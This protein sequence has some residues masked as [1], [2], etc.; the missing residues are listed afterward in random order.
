MRLGTYML[1]VLA[2]FALLAPVAAS[3]DGLDDAG[4]TNKTSAGPR[5][6]D[7]QIGQAIEREFAFDSGVLAERIDVQTH[8]GIV[9]LSG[10]TDNLLSR[11]RAEYLAETVKGVRSVVNRIEVLPAVVKSDEDLARD[12]ED[13]LA[14]DPATRSYKAFVESHH[15]TV[16]LSGTVDSPLEKRLVDRVA[17]GVKGVR[18]VE[19]HVAVAY[20]APRSDAEIEKEVEAALHWDPLIDNGLVEVAVE[21]GEVHLVGTVGSAAERRRARED[22]W[23]SGVHHVQDDLEVAHWARDEE[24]R[25]EKYV[26]KSDEDIAAA[27]MAALRHDPRVFSFDVDTSV[28]SG[29]V[30]LTGQVN[31]IKARRAAGRDAANTIGV[32]S[33]ENDLVV[34]P[35]EPYMDEDVAIQVR[36]AVERNPYL[37]GTDI[38]VEVRDGTAFLAGVIDSYFG[39]GEA[40][41]VASRVEG[42]TSVVNNLVVSRS[43]LLSYNPYVDS[44]DVYDFDWYDPQLGPPLAQDETIRTAIESEMWWSPFVDSEEVDVEVEDGVATLTGTVDSW[45]EWDAASASA[46]EGGAIIVVNDLNVQM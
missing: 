43:S 8:A 44:W 9:E 19:N 4:T 33:V 45:R 42:V 26:H 23:T 18:S 10:T 6:T 15:G 27:V 3:S 7:T 34:E 38:D 36:A 14:A 46:Y 13:A 28:R 22:A 1:R 11:D 25:A 31:N 32:R 5:M 37:D 17:R 39:K 12:V 20:G 30:H 40:D 24:L 41:E 16:S 21:D 29:E 35:S 2:S